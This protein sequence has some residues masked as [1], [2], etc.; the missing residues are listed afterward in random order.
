MWRKTL[1]LWKIILFENP[2]FV[3]SDALTYFLLNFLFLIP[4]LNAFNFFIESIV[5]FGLLICVSKIYAKAKGDIKAFRKG[6]EGLN[7]FVCVKENFLEAVALSLAHMVMGVVALFFVFLGLMIIALITGTTFLIFNTVPPLWAL[8]LYLAFLLFVYFSIVTSYPSFFARVIF[9]A[10]T[11]KDYFFM[12]ITAP[13]SNLLFK[14]SFSLDLLA[15]SLIIGGISL[16]L[17]LFKVFITWL[18]PA[19]I[20]FLSFLVLINILLV[21]L[22]GVVAVGEFVWKRGVRC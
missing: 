7:A 6:L 19:S 5:T 16:L 2:N 12:F 4:L 17:T 21:Y 20:L 1:T 22:F 10:K 14:M 15:S 11:P 3:L 8:A 13:F 9:E 18:F